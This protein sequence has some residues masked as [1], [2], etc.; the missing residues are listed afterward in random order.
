MSSS[1]FSQYSSADRLEKT[2]LPPAAA[3][4]RPLLAATRGLAAAGSAQ[5]AHRCAGAAGQALQ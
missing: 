1:A 2:S 4:F 3:A 5:G